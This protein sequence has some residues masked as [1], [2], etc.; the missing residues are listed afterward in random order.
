MLN[1]TAYNETM[2][3]PVWAMILEDKEKCAVLNPEAG[4]DDPATF[5]YPSDNA[6]SAGGFAM[7][8]LDYRQKEE[9]GVSGFSSARTEEKVK[10]H[11][12]ETFGSPSK[13]HH[14]LHRPN[15]LF[16]GRTPVA[17]LDID[18]A[19]VEA[20]LIRIDHGIYI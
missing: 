19:V 18:S 10:A 12:L 16:G 7:S 14:W 20:E 4:W 3:E 9:R 1:Q 8:L 5:P 6:K 11:V 13:A 15:A 17:M 2:S